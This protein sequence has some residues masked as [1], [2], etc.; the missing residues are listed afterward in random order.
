MGCVSRLSNTDRR[1][2]CTMTHMSNDGDRFT[3]L[4]GA[5]IKGAIAARDWSARAVAKETGHSATALNGWLNGRRALP[6]SVLYEITELVGISARDVVERAYLRMCEEDGTEP[7][8]PT[9]AAASVTVLPTGRVGGGG[10]GDGDVAD[11][12]PLLYGAAALDYGDDP[13]QEA[14]EQ[15]EMP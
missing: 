13:E 2:T 14:L 5:E 3:A 10:Y 8:Q 1:Q 15:A 6:L 9:T 12:D 4:V 11:P 7:L